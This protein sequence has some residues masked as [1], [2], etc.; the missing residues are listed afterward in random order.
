LCTEG[1]AESHQDT[2]KGHLSIQA[3]GMVC[4]LILISPVRSLPLLDD[5]VR[6]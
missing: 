2:R 4:H 3:Q 5:T 6:L 1:E